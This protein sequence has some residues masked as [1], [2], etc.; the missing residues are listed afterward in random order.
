MEGLLKRLSDDALSSDARDLRQTWSEFEGCLTR[1]LQFEERYLLPA[2]L[3]SH[4]DEVQLVL[5][6]HRRI[7]ECVADL[8]VEIDLHVARRD[9]VE[10]LIRRLRE[11]A[12]NEE[13]TLYYWTGEASREL[14]D[15]L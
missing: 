8:G 10:A 5:T 13:R 6:E 14:L 2:V 15:R 1:H 3:A 11:H 9:A 7:R 12:Q 4:P